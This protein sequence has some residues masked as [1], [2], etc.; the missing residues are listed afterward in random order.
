VIGFLILAGLVALFLFLTLNATGSGS[1]P[2]EWQ[3]ILNVTIKNYLREV[4]EDTMRDFKLVAMLQK[5]GNIQ[6]NMSGDKLNWRIRYKQAPLQGI[7]DSDTLTFSRVDRHKI[8]ELEWR[9]YAATDAVTFKEKEMNKGQEAIVNRFETVSSMLMEDVLEKFGYEPYVNGY[10]TGNSKRFHG[11]ESFLATAQTTPGT[12]AVSGS[13]AMQPNA[14]YAG[15]N[16]ALGS[17]GGNWTPAQQTGQTFGWPRGFGSSEYDFYSPLI[18]DYTSTLATA[19]GGWSSSTATW[20]SRGLEVLRFGITY[21]QKNKS[22]RGML[23]YIDLER[24][25]YRLALGQ[26]QTEERILVERNEEEGLT[27]L[28]FRDVFNFDG[29]EITTEYA[30]PAATGYGFNCNHVDIHSLM[31]QMWTPAGPDEDIASM[32]Y[33]FA[34]FNWGNFRWRPRYFLKLASYGSTGA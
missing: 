20:A 7:A 4:E 18:L 28:G 19:S 11:M 27:S 31:S 26:I 21:S 1:G 6:Y 22:K 12:G 24:E 2:T 13:P 9:G 17:Y 16:T 23:D 30:I 34:I 29:C 33:R 8:A 14:T 10:A 3:G 25:L 32:A 5:R 15:I